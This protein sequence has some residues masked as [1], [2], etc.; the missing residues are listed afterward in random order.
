MQISIVTETYPP[1]INGVANT[2]LRTARSETADKVAQSVQFL[3]QADKPA[4]L[5]EILSADRAALNWSIADR[6][7]ESADDT[8]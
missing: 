6:R 2:L 7:L 3:A 5:R 8:S 4:R 1:E